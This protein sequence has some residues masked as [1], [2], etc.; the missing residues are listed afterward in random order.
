MITFA[1]PTNIK[2]DEQ[3]ILLNNLIH[4]IVH[5]SVQIPYEI[6][7]CGN[8][9]HDKVRTIEFPEDL[10][11][12]AYITRKQNLLLEEAKYETIVFLRDYEVL[13]SDWIDGYLYWH[14]KNQDNWT[15]ML[16]PVLNKDNTRWRD[17]CHWDKPGVGEPWW[18]NEAWNGTGRLT[19]GSPHL[20]PY[21]DIE[22]GYCYIN[23][24]YFVSKRQFLK[25]NKWNESLSWGQ[26]EDVEIS[27]RIRTHQDFN[28]VVNHYSIVQLQR[29]KDRI[30]PVIPSDY[31][32]SFEY[33]MS[34]YSRNPLDKVERIC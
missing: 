25:Q 20:C 15:I 2:S 6:L 18:Q 26:G 33:I 10:N 1:V 14:S 21:S 12:T 7:V 32:A 17:V 24:G 3:K 23:G 22:P 34:K 27:L 16:S 29:Q 4:S 19:M 28:Y 30:L 31:F 9:E 8:F 13:W 11:G 5:Q